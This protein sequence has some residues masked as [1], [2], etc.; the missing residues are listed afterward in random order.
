[1]KIANSL[2]IVFCLLFSSTGVF[3]QKP[4]QTPSFK[5]EF[6]KF[7][8]PNGLQVIFHIDRSDPV[9]AVN[10]TAHVG[11]AREKAGRTGFAHMFEHLLFLES[12][13]LGK[14]GLDAMTARIG[15]SG[16][17]GSTSR[18]RTNYLQT[19]P[20]DALEKMQYDLY[21]IKHLSI[22]FDLTIVFDTVKVV[23]FRKGAA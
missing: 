6:E 12:E 10:L 17:N 15:G 5:V 8:L 22:F 16:A 21:Y 4:A 20:K 11:S 2:L 23:L 1:M 14:G 19:V 18:D 7:T 13:N 3:A 9:V